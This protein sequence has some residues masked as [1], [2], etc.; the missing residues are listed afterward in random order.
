MGRDSSCRFFR[1]AG[2]LVSTGFSGKGNGLDLYAVPCEGSDLHVAYDLYDDVFE[3]LF[4]RAV[5]PT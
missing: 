4:F 1:A 3:G 5:V 2:G